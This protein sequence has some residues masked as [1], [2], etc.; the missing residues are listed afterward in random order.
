MFFI[1]TAERATQKLLSKLSERRSYIAKFVKDCLIHLNPDCATL[2]G[3]PIDLC[4]R[5]VSLIAKHRKLLFG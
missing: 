5:Q 3:G 1:F 2:N 4:Y